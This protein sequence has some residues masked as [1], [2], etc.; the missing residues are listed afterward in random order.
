MYGTWKP[1][2]Y[3]YKSPLAALPALPAVT[4]IAHKLGHIP[5]YLKERKEELRSKA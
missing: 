4:K 1:I 3:Y 2:P 5:K